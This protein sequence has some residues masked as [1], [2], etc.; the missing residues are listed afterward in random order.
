MPTPDDILQLSCP[1]DLIQA[2]TMFVTRSLVHPG[3]QQV[4]PTF[5]QLRRRVVDKAVELAF[6]RLLMEEDIPH[7]LIDSVTFSQPDTYD[8]AFGGRRCVLVGMSISHREE[9]NQIHNDLG[10]LTKGNVYLR[11]S[12]RSGT[13]RDIDLYI[14]AFLT[15]LVTRSRQALQKA[16]NASQPVHLIFPLPEEWAT[17]A[18]WDSLGELALKG[19]ISVPVGIT[20]SGQ[21]RHRG[22]TQ[23]TV[24]VPSRERVKVEQDFNTLNVLQASGL[25]DGPI[26]V[27]SPRLR[28]TVL[29][30]PYQWGNVWVY[31]MRIFLMGYISLGD[32]HRQAEILPKGSRV[33]GNPSLDEEGLSIP[34]SVIKPMEDLF[35]RAENWAQQQKSSSN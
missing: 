3:G 10:T 31:G 18:Q 26:G 28:K 32:F 2:G 16:L 12:R 23:F 20:L 21:D 5:D 11:E 34:V 14:F 30:S 33:I 15:G 7:H 4:N 1:E 25:P 17:P 22:Y 13:Y 35:I 29:V 19:D 9:I 27:S 24:E 8:V 6:R